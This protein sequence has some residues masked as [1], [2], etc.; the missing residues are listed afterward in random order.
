[1]DFRAKLFLYFVV[2]SG[3]NICCFADLNDY[4][5]FKSCLIQYLSEKGKLD[6]PLPS[7]VPPPARCRV[8]MPFFVNIVIE[9]ATE[10]IAPRDADCIRNETASREFV[11][12]LLKYHVRYST[13]TTADEK[14][15]LMIEQMHQ[16]KDALQKLDVKCNSTNTLKNLTLEDHQLKYCMRKYAMDNRL[17]NIT[18]ANPQHI[19][20]DIVDCASIVAAEQKKVEAEL[21]REISASDCVVKDFRNSNL[22]HWKVVSAALEDFNSAFVISEKIEEFLDMP[23]SECAD[24]Q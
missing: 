12:G 16:T 5:L 18:D 6:K 11:D 19:D 15:S 1:M 24:L 3:A 10:T 23:S 4:P 20:T 7:S 9:K 14:F 17:L 8:A 22:F 2:L 13:L 21:K